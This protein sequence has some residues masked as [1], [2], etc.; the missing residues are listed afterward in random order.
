MTYLKELILKDQ[1][2]LVLA[3]TIA[4]SLVL[5]VLFAIYTIFLRLRN[6]RKARY[7][8]RLEL[9]WE[10]AVLNILTGESTYGAVRELVGHH[11]SVFF[12]DYCQ[13][14]AQRLSGE[15][16]DIIRRLIEPYLP[17]LAQRVQK[18]DPPQRA[19]AVRTLSMLGFEQYHEVIEAALDDPSPLVAMIAARALSQ[20]GSPECIAAVMERL[21]RFG[22]WSQSYLASM[23]TTV[24]PKAT[25]VLRYTLLDP[26][27][28]A[29]VRTVAA[30]ALRALNDLEA[31]DPVT[32][33]LTEETDR[34]LTAAILRLLG[35]VGRPEHLQNV[36]PLVKSDDFV[37]RAQ[38]LRVLGELGGASEL[39]IL[40]RGLEDESPW[41]TIQ[42]ARG[43]REA[44]GENL[45]R[46]LAARDHPR[47]E[48]ARQ[49]LAEGSV[50]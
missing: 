50:A 32:A 19:R 28:D 33:V 16:A 49:V 11:E 14:F 12:I 4:V 5:V 35:K 2:F 20:R 48:L 38:A 41:T 46:E 10:P 30:D 40:K 31:G 1:V 21:H 15:E 17:A 8:R 44:G 43:L 7:W 34:D 37:V 6:I 13:R 22:N 25:P 18:G 42:A 23:L 45:L 26:Q 27:K 24:G 9:L 3:I 47:S 36:R 29:R 39:E